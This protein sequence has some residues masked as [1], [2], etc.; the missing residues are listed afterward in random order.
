MDA[1]TGLQDERDWLPQAA[2]HQVELGAV[3]RELRGVVLEPQDAEPTR[4]LK[5]RK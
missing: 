3:V 2:V 4:L 5:E 1:V